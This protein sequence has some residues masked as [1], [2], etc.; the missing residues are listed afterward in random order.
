MYPTVRLGLKRWASCNVGP[1]I[2]TSRCMKP[3]SGSANIQ[4]SAKRQNLLWQVLGNSLLTFTRRSKNSNCQNC[5][6]A[7]QNV[8]AMDLN[9]ENLPKVRSAGVTSL[10]CGV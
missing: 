3:Y 4:H 10:N 8:A 5:S 9:C 7:S 2:S 6:I 1:T